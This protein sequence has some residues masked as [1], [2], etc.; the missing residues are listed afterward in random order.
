MLQMLYG[1]LVFDV[2][3]NILEII[4]K[5]IFLAIAQGP[6]QMLTFMMYV[7]PERRKTVPRTFP[8][9]LSLKQGILK[10][11]FVEQLM[12]ACHGGAELKW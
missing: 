5:T 3:T 4:G 6:Q 11:N 10:M 9:P 12:R 1:V 8:M 7:I 2:L